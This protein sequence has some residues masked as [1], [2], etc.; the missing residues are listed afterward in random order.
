MIKRPADGVARSEL[1]R[2]NKKAR[3]FSVPV[4]QALPYPVEH[5]Y[6]EL[7]GGLHGN[8]FRRRP[9]HRFGD[10]LRFC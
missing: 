2:Y 8:E 6:I 4:G 3:V 5:M 10:R 7:I 9:P 1:L